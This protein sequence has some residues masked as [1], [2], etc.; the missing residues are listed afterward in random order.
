MLYKE[1]VSAG[2]LELLKQLM[3]DEQLKDFFL[4]GG[5]ALSLL[6]GHRQSIDIDLFCLH[7]FDENE[8][9]AYLERAWGFKLDYQG[10]NTLKGQIEKVKV[11]FITHAY[12]LVENIEELDSIRFAGLMDIAA[13][14][15]N[16]IVGNGT[17]VKDFIDI[18]YLSAYL[19]LNEM[20]EAYAQKYKT[21]NIVMV[22]KSLEYQVDIDHVEPIRLIGGKYDWD[23]IEVRLRQMLKDPEDALYPL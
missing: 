22:L 12:P 10:T 3:E 4:V 8:M 21:R 15:L 20:L 19:S 2:T 5:T 23:K 1:T 6:I 16:A 14:K 9:L 7:G 18:A 17:R 11:D 13:M